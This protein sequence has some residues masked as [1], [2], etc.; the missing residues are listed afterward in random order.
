[1]WKKK[2]RRAPWAQARERLDR[3]IGQCASR[4][5]CCRFSHKGSQASH[6]CACPTVPTL[7]IGTLDWA[8]TQP[9]CCTT[10]AWPEAREKAERPQRRLSST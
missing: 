5:F 7:G 3:S 9:P 4:F 8:S 2:T 6:E 10:I 1:V